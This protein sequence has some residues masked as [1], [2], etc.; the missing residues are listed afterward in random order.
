METQKISRHTGNV[1]DPLI[2]PLS[3]EKQ[4]HIVNHAEDQQKVSNSFV[5]ELEVRACH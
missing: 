5:N 1:P 2:A 3:H 4:K